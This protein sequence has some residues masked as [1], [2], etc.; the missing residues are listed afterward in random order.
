MSGATLSDAIVRFSVGARGV[1][2]DL[3]L[4]PM[5]NAEQIASWNGDAGRHWVAES[6][7]YDRMSAAFS[8]MVFAAADPRPGERVLDIGCGTGALCMAAAERVVPGGEVVG[9]DISAP[10]LDKARSRAAAA[11][12]TNAAFLHADAQTT[13]FPQPFDAA[14]SR[15]GVMF[16]ADPA[17]AFANIA[18][19]LKPGGRLVFVCWQD[20]LLNEWLTVPVF[21]ALAHVPAP[22]LGEGDQPGGFSLADPRRVSALLT[23]AGFA[24]LHIEAV[25]ER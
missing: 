1:G 20:F 10:M 12:L 22:N 25:S 9:I 8:T 21:A 15:F 17:I 23:N 14:V 18:Q 13:T 16:F 3:R 11:G 6:D 5:S 19:A 24:E 4:R 2:R 7:R